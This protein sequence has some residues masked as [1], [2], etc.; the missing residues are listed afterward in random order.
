MI[1][2]VMHLFYLNRILK[3]NNAKK[4]I[5]SNEVYKIIS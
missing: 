3:L 4:L 5:Y 2:I 1:S